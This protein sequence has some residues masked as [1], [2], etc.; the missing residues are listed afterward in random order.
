MANS[1][2]IGGSAT[3]LASLATLGYS[4]SGFIQSSTQHQPSILYSGFAYSGYAVMA[5]FGV[6]SLSFGWIG[7]AYSIK[8]RY[9]GLALAGA[10]LIFA[11]CI[12]EFFTFMYAPAVNSA[13]P[14]LSP[15]ASAEPIIIMQMLVS[16]EA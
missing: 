13:G 6:L 9:F 16:L 7:A 15:F 3:V 8:R 10:F 1:S 11:S 2:T 12:V 5:W 14:S 4:I